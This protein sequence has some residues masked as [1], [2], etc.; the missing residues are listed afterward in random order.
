VTDKGVR[1]NRLA[2]REPPQR[3]L[4]DLVQQAAAVEGVDGGRADRPAAHG[5]ALQFAV[6]L[7]LALQDED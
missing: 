1:V 4:A 5:P 2:G 3:G 6:R 7:R